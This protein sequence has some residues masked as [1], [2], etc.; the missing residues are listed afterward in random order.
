VYR[1]RTR[2]T[3]VPL[4]GRPSVRRTPIQTRYN[5]SRR[6]SPQT[7]PDDSLAVLKGGPRTANAEGP[8]GLQ[9]DTKGD[10][11]L[12]TRPARPV[13]AAS[14]PP[15][16]HQR[17]AGGTVRN[18]SELEPTDTVNP[19]MNYIYDIQPFLVNYRT[20][21]YSKFP[22]SGRRA[23]ADPRPNTRGTKVPL[24]GSPRVQS[25]PIQPRYNYG[26]QGT[27]QIVPEDSLAALKGGPR[28][29][30][31]EGHGRLRYD[32]RRDSF[33]P[34]RPTRPAPAA[35][36]KSTSPGTTAPSPP[37]SLAPSPHFSHA[38][39]LHFSHAPSLPVSFNSET[40]H[41]QQVGGGPLSTGSSI[42]P[43]PAPI[44]LDSDVDQGSPIPPKDLPEIL[45]RTLKMDEHGVDQQRNERT[46]GP[47]SANSANE[48]IYR[49]SA[50]E[51][52]EN[53]SPK[54][55]LNAACL[56]SAERPP[57]YRKAIEPERCWLDDQDLT[58]GYYFVR[59]FLGKIGAS[60]G[61]S[62]PTAP[63]STP[64]DLGA[65]I[66][67]TKMKN[68]HRRLPTPPSPATTPPDPLLPPDD[69]PPLDGPPPQAPQRRAG[70]I[71]RNDSKL[72]ST[73]TVNPGMNYIHNIHT[74]LVN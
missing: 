40:D 31:A 38:P 21:G 74:C 39:S 45:P 55:A 11:I 72:E 50:P 22:L 49:P 9:Y 67:L 18:D 23:A 65:V 70:G 69:P 17:R 68:G 66:S 44:S 60:Q 63:Q 3:E 19:G 46:G 53:L 14:P 27:P 62:D 12:P 61:E 71:A 57:P 41:K 43:L 48:Q 20:L 51:P 25:K 59:R 36:N 32:T 15:H 7:V 6:G 34:I 42:R 13:P 37:S 24:A 28:P 5:H 30:N 8:G 54:P 2:S 33:L 47:T 58:D 16:A 1:L 35:S 4:A 73:D 29:A 52:H 26:H 64:P 56:P 10:S